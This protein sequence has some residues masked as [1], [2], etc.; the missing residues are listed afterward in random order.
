[1]QEK[2]TNKVSKM[3]NN[4]MKKPKELEDHAVS[5]DS[6]DPLK[7]AADNNVFTN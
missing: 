2:Y 5:F 6:N 7:Y 1:M 4:Y 3:K